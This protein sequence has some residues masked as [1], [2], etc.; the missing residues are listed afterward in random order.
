MGPCAVC[1]NV[2]KL[3]LKVVVHSGQALFHK[4]GRFAQVSGLDVILVHRLLKNSIDSDEYV[5]MTESAYRDITIV[6]PW[7]LV[8]GIERYE[9][10]GEVNT[11]VFRADGSSAPT[12]EAIQRL[13]KNRGSAFR[14]AVLL[15]VQGTFAQFPILLGM[16]PAGKFNDFGDASNPVQVRPLIRFGMALRLLV[17][18]PLILPIGIVVQ[19]YRVLSMKTLAQR[20]QH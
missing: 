15:I 1:A 14:S 19:A 13:Y 12:P 11:Y 4:V 6:S 3:K 10:I 9:G 17:M 8:R 2:D 5:L 18:V 16:R 20:H 7:P